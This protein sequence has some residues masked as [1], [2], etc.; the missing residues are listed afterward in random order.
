MKGN[1]M[2]KKQGL[3]GVLALVSEQS[4]GTKGPK[5][6]PN[7]HPVSLF[8]DLDNFFLPAKKGEEIGTLVSALKPWGNV[9]LRRAYGSSL[10][11]KRHLYDQLLKHGFKLCE[12]SVCANTKK[13]STDI[14]ITIDVME[15]LHKR[16][17]I[18]IYSIGCGDSDYISLIE[19][20]H[21]ARKFVI[22][23]GSN[24]NTSPR[25]I[26]TCDAFLFYE[27]IAAPR[28]SRISQTTIS[29]NSTSIKV[30]PDAMKSILRKRNL[31]PADV[32]TRTKILAEIWEMRN[33]VSCT[34][35][36]FQTN[37]FE[38][39]ASKKISNTAVRHCL[40]A[41]VRAGFLVPLEDVPALE[42]SVTHIPK[43]E[44]MESGMC[45]V[46]IETLLSD[47]DL[48]ADPLAMAE[49]VYGNPRRAN[50]IEE[51][52]AKASAV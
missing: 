8:L 11:P 33:R 9:S 32:E 41:L 13:N 14:Q 12:R 46:M 19:R 29:E 21:K 52:I 10:A 48:I 35:R 3:K 17:E 28:T 38:R 34:L 7:I 1:D 27:E 36:D 42:R 37:L 44:E 30:G 22:G 31:Y 23:L 26:K 24:K 18:A 20:L 15:M 5:Y 40:H 25:L 50:E 4:K 45:S 49:V 16:P 43:I 47:P 2:S 51:F 39:C 6:Y